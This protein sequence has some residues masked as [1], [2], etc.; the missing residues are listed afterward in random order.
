MQKVHILNEILEKLKEYPLTSSQ[1]SQ[2]SNWEQQLLQCSKRKRRI[3]DKYTDKTSETES[4]NA[5]KRQKREKI[6]KK[7][8]TRFERKRFI[9]TYVAL[10]PLRW[11]KLREIAKLEYRSAE[12][13]RCYGNA[14]LLML[15]GYSE[16]EDSQFLKNLIHSKVGDDK[17]SEVSLNDPNYQ[18][19]L[20]RKMKGWLSKL[21]LFIQLKNEVDGK[22]ADDIEI[23]LYK[24]VERRPASWW[25][26]LE[27][28]DLLLSSYKH[29]LSRYR[30]I[31]SDPKYCFHARM[32][33]NIKL[34]K[35]E[36]INKEDEEEESEDS[37]ELDKAIASNFPAPRILDSRLKLLLNAIGRANVEKERRKERELRKK[38]RE[39]LKKK[40]EFTK[41]WARLEKYELKKNV[42]SFGRNY[43][44][45]YAKSKL[46]RPIEQIKDH[47]DFLITQCEEVVAKGAKNVDKDGAPKE[48]GSKPEG[49]DS[50]NDDFKEEEEKDMELKEEES[51][52]EI[53]EDI[54]LNTE[55][56]TTE[57]TEMEDNEIKEVKEK[58]ADE[59]S[60]KGEKDEDETKKIKKSCR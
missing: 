45:I 10:G 36:R 37:L 52:T 35:N 47:V 24:E 5:T 16:T 20:K 46:D 55:T 17:Y 27:D 40:S 1:Q 9:E 4:G 34:D 57:R 19:L 6:E 31:F 25:T 39:I 26:A 32:P 28:R 48:N 54:K 12:E 53:K 14:F 59:K 43:D 11:D 49:D 21:K 60:E 58:E 41:E 38:E 50:D 51:K 33:E 23:P 7:L 56:R 15:A 3:T 2:V 22:D 29:G 18:D 8:W 42:L 44:V 13:L 30:A